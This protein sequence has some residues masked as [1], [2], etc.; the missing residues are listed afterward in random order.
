MSP[1]DFT[2]TFMNET[3]GFCEQTHAYVRVKLSNFDRRKSKHFNCF[4]CIHLGGVLLKIFR[5]SFLN[6]HECRLLEFPQVKVSW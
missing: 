3:G 4:L 1:E 6:E 2:T 5:K